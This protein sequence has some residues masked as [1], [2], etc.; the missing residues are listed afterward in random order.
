MTS[1]VIAPN[2]SSVN[3]EVDLRRYEQGWNAIPANSVIKKTWIEWKNG[4]IN[5]QCNPISK[6][7][8]DK[9]KSENAFKDGYAVIC[10]QLWHGGNADL[11]GI[12]LDFDN[13]EAV[14]RYFGSWEK[15]LELAK[16]RRIEWHQKNYKLHYPLY[17]R[18]PIKNRN[19]PI[20]IE[21]RAENEL[22]YCWK[23]KDLNYWVPIDSHDQL[24]MEEDELQELENWIEEQQGGKGL[25]TA[26]E[27][28]NPNYIKHEN[29]NRSLD[30]LQEMDS[31]LIRNNGLMDD[32]VIKQ[33]A[34]IWHNKHCD[35][36]YSVSKF[37]ENWQQ[38]LGFRDARIRERQLQEEIWKQYQNPVVTS[39]NNN[40]SQ[41]EQPRQK[42]DDVARWSEKLLEKYNH[43]QTVVAN[44]LPNMWIGLEFALSVKT[45]LNIKDCTL[46]FAGIILGS[47]SS[48]KS[49][50]IELLKRTP[51]T[52]YTHDFSPSSW[53]THNAA[54]KREKLKDYDMLPRVKNKLFLTPELAPLFSQR[55]DDLLKS[56]AVLTAIL[57]GHGFSSDTGAQ[58]HRSYDEDIMFT[59]LGASVDIPYKVHK[60]LSLLGPKLYFFRLPKTNESE[61]SYYE[62]KDEIF[63]TK[64]KTIRAAL[65]DYFN[66]FETNPYISYEPEN[67]LSKIA[68]D[69]TKDEEFAHRYIIKLGKLLAP[70]RAVV[71]TWENKETGE[72]NFD[73]AIVE[74]PSRAITQLRNIARGHALSQ[75]RFHITLDDIPMLIHVVLSTCSLARA[76]IFDILIENNGK[77][78][79]S[80]IVQSLTIVKA[81][82][83][84]T[85]TELRATGL[86]DFKE[87]GAGYRSLESEIVLKEEFKWFLSPTFKDLRVKRLGKTPPCAQPT[88]SYINNKIDTGESIN[89]CAHGGN[90]LNACD[91][92]IE[93][94]FNC[95]KCDFITAS[96]YDI[97]WH[98]SNIHGV[99]F[100]S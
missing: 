33:C 56:L 87:N 15:V 86:V 10:G 32:E 31:L 9:W 89:A 27:R 13:W 34:Q 80:Q 1:N 96:R 12:W 35:P 36:P 75:G 93:E 49:Q 39:N 83:L 71:P 24:I 77:L 47:P 68:L 7:Q 19:L 99:E 21:V 20:G 25:S 97:K 5:F 65:E 6:E 46:P 54:I 18:R 29:Q 76:T 84:K 95:Q 28:N 70:L 91:K 92:H 40:E 8:H 59:W 42:E 78:S 11:Y 14:I 50:I 45:I 94:N 85:M 66:Y 100:S 16:T 98:S 43:L 64:F 52:Y 41:K 82:A 74:D 22:V 57:D 88:T 48:L 81:T 67:D 58:G 2:N 73:F 3:L 62:H 60:H 4:P 79:T 55:D 17:T 44:N 51:N 38:A 23:N 72:Y 30:L 90:S 37:E 26:L 69:H 63:G 61:D 53:V